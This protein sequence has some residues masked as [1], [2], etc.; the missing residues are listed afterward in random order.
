L[1]NFPDNKFGILNSISLYLKEI[2]D[3]E[4][5]EK[6]L[7]EAISQPGMFD[8]EQKFVL[9]NL[10]ELFIKSNRIDSSQIYLNKTA[11][12][13]PFSNWEGYNYHFIQAKIDYHHKN[14]S[15][16]K[17][18]ITKAKAYCEDMQDDGNMLKVLLVESKIL[19]K[20]K[21]WSNAQDL[22]K[23]SKKIKLFFNENKK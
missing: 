15:D 8:F 21:E 20:Q 19:V 23:I 2:G 6:Y 4:L 3:L 22:L 5:S 9:F 16:A 14:Y 7:R 12:L 18:S 13:Q 11:L 1:K 17:K 10:A